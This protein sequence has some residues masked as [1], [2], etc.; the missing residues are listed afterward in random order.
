MT[1][2]TNAQAV[3]DTISLVE[4]MESTTRCILLYVPELGWCATDIEGVSF[5]DT[6]LVWRDDAAV[7]V[8][9]FTG[10]GCTPTQDESARLLEIVT[11]KYVREE[12]DHF[13]CE[14]WPKSGW[15]RPFEAG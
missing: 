5:A 1:S 3:N 4:A 2:A 9:G 7:A 8:S 14:W 11:A 12:G 10:K 15:I 13:A 6:R